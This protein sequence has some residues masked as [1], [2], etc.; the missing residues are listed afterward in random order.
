MSI[1]WVSILENNSITASENPEKITDLYFST[2]QTVFLKIPWS[3]SWENQRRIL[4]GTAPQSTHTHWES[5]QVHKNGPISV[6]WSSSVKV[7]VVVEAIVA[8]SV[9]KALRQVS[10]KLPL[11]W[12]LRYLT[13]KHPEK[14]SWA[15]Q[16]YFREILQEEQMASQVRVQSAW[17]EN[18]REL[19]EKYLNV[20]KKLRKG[21]WNLQ[22]AYI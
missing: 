19:R 18:R 6:F 7:V 1:N 12:N 15:H 8:R 9:E 21:D 13:M 20:I 4:L 10:L 17:L 3:G 5:S 16:D 14:L 11:S 2:P 22:V